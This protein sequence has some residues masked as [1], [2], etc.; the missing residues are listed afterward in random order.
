VLYQKQGGWKM[1]GVFQS[2][3]IVS[4]IVTTLPRASDV[5]KQYRI[6]FCCGGKRPLSDA[7][8]EKGLN[9]EEVLNKLNQLYEQTQ[10]DNEQDINWNEATCSELIDQIVYKHHAYLSEELPQLS[11]YV[12]KILRVHGPQHKELADVHQLF[13]QMKTELEQ[14]TIKEENEIFPLILKYEKNPSSEL[15]AQLTLSI[16]ELE[17]EHETA[18]DILKK[19]RDVTRD[20]QLPEGAC[21]TYRLTF[22]RL[23]DLESDLFHHIH[24]ENNILFPRLLKGTF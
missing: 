5:L 19:L 15:L 1:E 4:D 6:D 13:H 16:K 14:H 9:E 23:E 2:S 11:P 8:Q 12:T 3:T 24:L 20:Y 22:K 18:G 7:V 17:E 10:T 21:M